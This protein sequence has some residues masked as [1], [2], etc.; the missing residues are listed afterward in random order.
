MLKKGANPNLVDRSRL[1]A[2]SHAIRGSKATERLIDLLVE[3]G[4]IIC[5]SELLGARETNRA[6]MQGQVNQLRLYKH[7]GLT[8]QVSIFLIIVFIYFLLLYSIL[9]LDL[10]FPFNAY[11]YCLN[12]L[13]FAFSLR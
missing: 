8:L 1:T 7:V 5:D 11:D 10:I 12:L 6:A 2:L 9:G 13:H 3:Y 4:A